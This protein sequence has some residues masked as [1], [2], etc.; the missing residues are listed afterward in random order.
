MFTKNHKSDLLSS[1]KDMPWQSE[2][3]PGKLF[4]GRILLISK[5]FENLIQTE[6]QARKNYHMED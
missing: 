3:T 4:S 1:A 2:Y 6:V 5:F